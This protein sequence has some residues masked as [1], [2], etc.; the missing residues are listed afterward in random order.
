[1]RVD[2]CRHEF[3]L[4]V[5]DDIIRNGSSFGLKLIQSKG[6]VHIRHILHGNGILFV[7]YQDIG[8]AAEVD[9]MDNV[10]ITN[11]CRVIRYTFEERSLI[12]VIEAFD[13]LLG[14]HF[15]DKLCRERP[16]GDAFGDER[17]GSE[18][19]TSANPGDC[20][21]EHDCNKQTG[22]KSE[23]FHGLE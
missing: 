23:N 1:M 8:I 14:P 11:H 18:S 17:Y 21:S 2:N 15:R 3:S 7:I 19:Y 12:D 16:G 5:V 20:C 9:Q 6:L 22:K 10:A 4:Y 13:K